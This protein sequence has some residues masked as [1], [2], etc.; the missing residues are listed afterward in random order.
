MSGVLAI[1]LVLGGMIFFH[2]LG[3]FL[4]A[5]LLG[6][7][8]KSFSIGF[9]KALFSWSGKKT[10]YRLGIFPLGGYVD[11][12]G[13]RR[14]EEVEAPFTPEE[15]YSA[16]GPAAR[17]L[18]VIAGPLFNILLAW[19]IYWGLIWGGNALILPEVGA[20]MP[21]SPAET[22]GFQPGDRLLSV[23]GRGIFSWDDLRYQVQNSQGRSLEVRLRRYEG[24]ESA[25]QV[26][27]MAMQA[28]EEGRGRTFYLLGLSAGG[29]FVEAS[30]F[31]AGL[32]GFKE[33]WSKTLFIMDLIRRLFTSELPLA[34]N[35]GGPVLVAQTVHQQATHSGLTGVLK[36][37]ALL[38]INLGLLNLLPIP[39]LD[40]GH[41]LFN[42]AEAIFR[43]PVP[44]RIQAV[45]AHFGFIFLI[46]LMI[47][48]TAFD[49]FR[50][51]G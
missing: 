46:G 41:V 36:L 34:E 31:R 49:I 51:A 47:L 15:S 50:L 18:A 6:I 27:P 7:G 39:A 17:L 40:G 48:A 16:R 23:N 44:D 42:L 12:V 28:G 1:V 2:E 38:S 14:D 3:H 19:F 10:V 9:G 20:I 11:L 5:R 37:T 32:E 13:M 25:L 26:V 4:A 33:A 22:A 45:C 8:V 30:F 29:G 21:G 24:N 35:L 43:R